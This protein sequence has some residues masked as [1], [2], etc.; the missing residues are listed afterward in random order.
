MRLLLFIGLLLLVTQGLAA[1][2]GHGKHHGPKPSLLPECQQAQS[3]PSPHCG[4]TPSL[5]FDGGQL[6]A[7][8]SQNGHVYL[9]ESDDHGKTFATPVAVNRSPESIYDDGENRPKIVFGHN[10]EIFVSWTRRI[11]GRYAGDVRFARSVDRGK[12]FDAPLTVNI[13]HAP[14]SHRFDSMIVDGEGRLYLLWID[15]RDMAAARKSGAEYSGAAIYYIVSSDGGLSFQTDRKL[16]DHSCECCRIATARDHEGAIVALW[17]HVYP[18]NMRDHAIAR[19][20][21]EQAPI[22]GLPTRGTDDGWQIDGCPHHGPDLA[23]DADNQAHMAWFSKGEKN[24]GLNYGRF[25]LETWQRGEVV[26][27]DDSPAAS[28]PQVWVNG[29]QVYLM[30]KRFDGERMLLLSKR[31]Q[32]GGRSW[33]A[34]TTI[35]STEND[36][37]HPD[38]LAADERLY[39]SWHTQSEGLRLIEV[40]P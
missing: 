40:K 24:K 17:R 25:D 22:H 12:T 34:E 31:S 3:L 6:F 21:P 19:V 13:D 32:D 23:I 4:R 35:A 26:T 5:A 33:D 8:F 1:K 18:V 11:E 7:V 28:R 9:S 36:S 2:D 15:K 38:W 16:V 14:I 39:A 27:F 30:W 29:R 20:Q 37:D 10:G